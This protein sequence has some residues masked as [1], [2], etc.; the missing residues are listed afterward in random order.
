[1]GCQNVA[2]RCASN[3]WQQQALV[4]GQFAWLAGGEGQVPI[5]AHELG[6]VQEACGA[7]SGEHMGGDGAGHAAQAC[8]LAESSSIMGAITLDSIMADMVSGGDAEAHAEPWSHQRSA[9]G[10]ESV[11]AVDD[12]DEVAAAR[13]VDSVFVSRAA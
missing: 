4:H 2:L 6:V 13:K 10:F 5:D 1:M 11:A 8:Q 7:C 3:G 9:Q 12:G